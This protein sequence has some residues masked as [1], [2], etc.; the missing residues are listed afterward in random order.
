MNSSS[1]LLYKIFLNFKI[2]FSDLSC[3]FYLVIHS[4]CNVLYFKC[5]EQKRFCIGNLGMKKG[6]GINCVS[7]G[8]RDSPGAVHS[9]FTSY[10]EL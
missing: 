10:Y 1:I 2:S 6:E 8:N 7:R 5:R 3:C 4:Y 9:C